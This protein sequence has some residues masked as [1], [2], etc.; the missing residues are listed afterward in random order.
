MTYGEKLLDPRWQKKRLEIL[1][2]DNWK[3]CLCED[4]KSTLHIHHKKYTGEPWDAVPENLQTLCIHCHEVV[5]SV[6]KWTDNNGNLIRILKFDNGSNG[7]FLVAIIADKEDSTKHGVAMYHY[8]NDT[9]TFAASI[10]SSFIGKISDV[11]QT[12]KSKV[13]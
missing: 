2:R 9:L 7:L 12:I 5:E 6:I 11:L 4:E 3:C 10:R 13:H 1:K 8:R